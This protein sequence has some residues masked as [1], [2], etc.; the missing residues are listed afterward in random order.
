MAEGHS[1]VE[2]ASCLPGGA[3]CLSGEGWGPECPPGH[4]TQ[5]GLPSRSWPPR[6][7]QNENQ[8]PGLCAIEACHCVTSQVGGR[9]GAGGS[10]SGS[11]GTLEHPGPLAPCFFELTGEGRLQQQLPVDCL[12]PGDK[13]AW[14]LGSLGGASGVFGLGVGGQGLG[15]GLGLG[16][17]SLFN[18]CGRCSDPEAISV[19]LDCWA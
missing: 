6:V 8:R 12:S 11:R 19:C 13:A 17:G 16:Y 10:L 15:L 5:T 1:S 7:T 3:G 2:S 18:S 9:E 4:H 14:R